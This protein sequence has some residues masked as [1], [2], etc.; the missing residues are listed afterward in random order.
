VTEEGSY[1]KVAVGDQGATEEEEEQQFAAGQ[2]GD[3]PA[4]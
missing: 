1:E 3:G 2:F 4:V